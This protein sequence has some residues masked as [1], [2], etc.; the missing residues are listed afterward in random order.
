MWVGTRA[1][2]SRYDGQRWIS[3]TTADGLASNEVESLL[4]DRQG[5]LWIGT[6]GGGVSRYDGRE[7]K[8]FTAADGLAHNRVSDIMEDREGHLWF[9]TWGGG[10]S[11]YDGLVFQTLLDRD[12]LASNATQEILQDRHGDFW[13]ATEGGIT[14]YRPHPAPPLIW[15]S[16]VIVDRDYGPIEAVELSTSQDYLAFQFHGGSFKTRPGQL[17]Y[18]YQLQGY[19]TDWRVTREERVV[20]TDLPRGDYVFAVKAV[21]RDLTYS[22]TPATVKVTVHLPYGQLAL[23]GGLAVALIGLAFA[24]GTAIRRRR[25]FLQ[26]QQ[27]RL[28]VQEQ[29]NR[30]L[31]EELQT[32]HNLQ[33]GLMPSQSP[34]LPGLDLAGRCVPANHV[35]GDFFQYFPQDGQLTLCLADVTGHAME[36]A[37][38]MVMF[39]GVLHS[40]LRHQLPL[41]QLFAD[42]NHTLHAR[43]DART[44]VC[45]SMAQLDLPARTLRLANGGSPYPYHFRAADQQV[46][47]LQVDAYPLG[48]RSDTRYQT[49]AVT[50]APGDY[51]VFCSDGI[52]EAVNRAGEMFGYDRTAEAV[53]SG[54]VEGLF[55]EELLERLFAAVRGFSAGT[56]RQDDQTVVAVKLGVA[57][58]LSSAAAS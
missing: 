43:L 32:A 29:L 10:V 52:I 57:G 12:G 39:S 33:M 13:I 28:Q 48:V 17:A 22:E 40:E 38:P 49:I 14:R 45:F 44:F 35:G 8:N 36:A 37:I 7:F 2:V 16:N 46:C 42:L 19:D 11:L 3:F 56:A 24:S 23:G 27:A 53:R 26:E 5:H 51:V 47:E 55:S 50:L 18:V 25:A 15:L 31:E 34:Q 54:C 21:D 4:E 9:A 20:Y 41:E 6:W 30:E 58:P 1:G